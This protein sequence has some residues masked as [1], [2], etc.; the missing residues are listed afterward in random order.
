MVIVLEDS[1][2]HFKESHMKYKVH[3]YSNS[4]NSNWGGSHPTEEQEHLTYRSADTFY[5][6]DDASH[7]F[8]FL[9]LPECNKFHLLHQTSS[10]LFCSKAAWWK[11]YIRPNSLGHKTG[12]KVFI[13]KETVSKEV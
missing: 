4:R 1:S 13:S 6:T 2:K 5:G 10:I 9:P 11:E 8:L 7:L 12:W 3:W